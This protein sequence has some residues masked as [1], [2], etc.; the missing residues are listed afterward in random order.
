[1][2]G[3]PGSGKTT[4]LKGLAEEFQP[5]G[6]VGFYTEEIRK[7][8][9]RRGFRLVG[10]DGSDRVL[11]HRRFKTAWHFGRYGVDIPG[12][13]TFLKGLDLA[14]TPS[15]LVFI[16]EIGKMECF[17]QV[18]RRLV[19]DLLD[20]DRTVV[21]TISLR[22]HGLIAEIRRRPDCGLVEIRPELRDILPERVSKRIRAL[23]SPSSEIV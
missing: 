20:S 10:L 17:S 21:A 6:P 8:G 7:Q 18:F 3:L 11:A 13:E 1:M 19:R 4:L 5:F 15:R 14:D 23:V 12:F 2:T 22:G 9:K 16:D